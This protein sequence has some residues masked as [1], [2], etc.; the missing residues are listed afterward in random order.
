MWSIV[1]LLRR[2]ALKRFRK[3]NIKVTQY[4]EWKVSSQRSHQLCVEL[5]LLMTGTYAWVYPGFS[6]PAIPLLVVTT[7]VCGVAKIIYWTW[8]IC[9]TEKVIKLSKILSFSVLK[10]I[11]SYQISQ[12]GNDMGF[13]NYIQGHWKMPKQLIFPYHPILKPYST[14]TNPL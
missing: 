2:A 8:S 7:T 1:F 4:L 6:I 10:W 14:T 5:H 11:R 13:L 9:S 12:G 3:N